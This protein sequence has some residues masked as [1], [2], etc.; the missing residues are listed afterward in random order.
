[1]K[2]TQGGKGILQWYTV[3][4]SKDIQVVRKRPLY[5]E[6]CRISVLFSDDINKTVTFAKHLAFPL[7]S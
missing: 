5:T 7:T 1:M 3:A 6:Y 4:P 2:Y